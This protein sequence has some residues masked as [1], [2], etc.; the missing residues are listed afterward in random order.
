MAVVGGDLYRLAPSRSIWGSDWPYLGAGPHISEPA[1]L[2]LLASYLPDET[3][4][5]SVL[6]HAPSAL[7]GKS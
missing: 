6:A 4:W 3:A 5:T 1:A 7:F 2:S